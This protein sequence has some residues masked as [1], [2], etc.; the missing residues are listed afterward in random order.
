MIQTNGGIGARRIVE[1]FEAIGYR[2]VPKLLYAPDFGV[3]QIRKRVFFVGL[4]DKEVSFQ[5]PEP[6]MTSDEYITCEDAID[7]LPSLQTEDGR[8]I[9]GEEEQ[10]YISS[11]RTD[12][13]NVQ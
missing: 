11:P 8:I 5:F 3:P 12:Y 10:D 6:I 9:Y 1:D 4:R 2:M 7:D 13:P